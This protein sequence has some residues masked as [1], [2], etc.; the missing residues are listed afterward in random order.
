MAEAHLHLWEL[1]MDVL[2]QM[3]G[4]VDGAVLSASASEAE[5]E[6]GEAA[7]QIALHMGIGQLTDMVE[8]A[9]YLAVVLQELDDGSVQARQV[10]VLLIAPGVV[11]AA[12][13]EDI[14]AAIAALVLRNAMLVAEAEDADAQFG[15]G[16]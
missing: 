11:G 12:A 6:R 1:A 13:V 8:E 14:A 15:G 9:Q 3:L 4:G 5:H 16:G 7:F 10:L 2:G